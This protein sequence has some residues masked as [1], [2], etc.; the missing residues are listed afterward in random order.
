MTLA[1]GSYHIIEIRNSNTA[2]FSQFLNVCTKV[3]RNFY[4][5]CL[6]RTPCR[7]H[8][9]FKTTFACL[10]MIF[11]RVNRII[12]ST[13]SFHMITAH[14]TTSRVFRLS[15]L[16]ITLVINLTGSLRAQDLIDTERCLQ[17]QVCPVIQRITESIR[18]GFSPL[19]KFFPVGSIL[20]CAETFVYTIGT[21]ST[22]F[23]MVAAQPDF[24]Q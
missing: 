2:Y 15:Q 5:H 13:N 18:N 22:P 10:N 3:S 14:H 20:T 24:S 21:H 11:Q 7:Q 12:R 17:L 6:V 4:S 1:Q 9:D 23:V 16:L 19:F 8:F